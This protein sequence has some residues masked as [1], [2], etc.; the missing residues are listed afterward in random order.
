MVEDVERL[1]RGDA[2]ALVRPAPKR[3]KKFKTRKKLVPIKT[4]LTEPQDT[5]EEVRPSKKT[6]LALCLA[7]TTQPGENGTG[8][9]TWQSA[10]LTLEAFQI[11]A[12]R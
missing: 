3:Y 8:Q 1:G 4:I 12:K 11:F 7:P 2:A 10:G 9:V 6:A 5:Q